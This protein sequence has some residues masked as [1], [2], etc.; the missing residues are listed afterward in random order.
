[1]VLSLELCREVD[2]GRAEPSPV[3]HRRN[4]HRKLRIGL[5]RGPSA[6]GLGAEFE[7]RNPYH[8]KNE[9]IRTIYAT[10]L[11]IEGYIG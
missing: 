10:K 9:F 5:G 4:R 11:T 1:M 3:L 2:G 6:S 8:G 7:T